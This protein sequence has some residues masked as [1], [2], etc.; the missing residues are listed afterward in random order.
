MR[1]TLYFSIRILIRL[2]SEAV[3]FG[4]CMAYAVAA[5]AGMPLL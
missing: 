1:V 3:G 2:V 4:D 5:V